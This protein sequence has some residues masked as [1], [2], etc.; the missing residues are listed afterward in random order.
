MQDSRRNFLK[1]AGLSLAGVGLG[2]PGCASKK[3][4]Y[5]VVV[6]GG[7]FGGATAARYIRKLDSSLSVALV[8]PEEN[9]ATCPFSNLVIAGE[10]SLGSVTQSYQALGEAHGVEIIH[11]WVTTIDPDK[12]TVSTKGGKT[13]GYEK[14]VVSPGIDFRFD[15]IEGYDETVAPD[16]P[17]AWKAGPQT[18]ALRRQLEA[19]PD[20]G[21]FVMVAPP[22]PF[23]CPP[24]PY[25]RASLVAHYFQQQ[26]PSSKIVILD[27]KSAFSKQGLFEEGWRLRYG[28]G[29]D[30]SMID[31]VSSTDGGKVV[32]IDAENREARTEFGDA[33]QADVLNVIPPQKAGWI[34]EQAGLTDDSGWCPVDQ[35]TYESTLL[36][37]IH[38]IGDAAVASPLPKSGYAANSEAKVCAAAVVAQLRGETVGTPTWINTCYSLV[39]PDY[40]I[41]VAMVYEYR[42]GQTAKVDGAGGVSPL[43]A[44]ANRPLEAGYA[45]DWYVN[46]T[47]DIWG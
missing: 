22:N 3:G 7:G 26:K 25:E 38:V 6:I 21:T 14:L 12:Q 33:I 29:T 41:S 32:G 30:D 34:A 10:R 1:V 39:A 20:G 9:Y 27:A 15:E 44:P 23:R 37:N 31:W 19:M 11:D 24:G 2:I 16:I 45:R 18:L 47:Q 40:G 8:E 28:F 46:I 5:D 13:L 42:D 35:Q 43:D 4:G 17:H 36:P